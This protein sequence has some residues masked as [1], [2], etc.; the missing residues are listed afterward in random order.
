MEKRL[1]LALALVVGLLTGCGSSALRVHATTIVLATTALEAGRSAIEAEQQRRF[2]ACADATC[3]T[4]AQ[5]ELRPLAQARDGLRT[6]VVVYREA[7]SAAVDLEAG[8][9]VL[10]SLAQYGLRLA[11][12]WQRVRVLFESLRLE[13][14]ALPV[15]C[16]GEEGP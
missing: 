7:V 1:L 5:N 11:C 15:G 12:E 9:E 16:V 13:L 14:P 4:V 10:P 3:L 6:L 8:A 2:T